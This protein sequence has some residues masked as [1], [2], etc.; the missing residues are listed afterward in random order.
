MAS[1]CL[2]CAASTALI[3]RFGEDELPW[4]IFCRQA[5]KRVSQ[6]NTKQA[7]NRRQRIRQDCILRNYIAKNAHMHADECAEILVLQVRVYF[8]TML[9]P[10]IRERLSTVAN[11]ARICG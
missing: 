1:S 8:S 7:P 6:T 11:R 9:T 10:R 4:A 3:S 5:Q 2:S